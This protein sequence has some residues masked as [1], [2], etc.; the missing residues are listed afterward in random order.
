M[1][2][3]PISMTEARFLSGLTWPD[4]VVQMSVNR[5]RITG[6]FEEIT[7]APHDRGDFA[8]AIARHGGQ[9][10][11]TAVAEDWCGDATLVLPLIAR[12]EA[13]IPGLN[14]RLFV[15]SD[16][17]DLEEAYAAFG[18]TRIPV[19]SFFDAD[20]QE[21]ARWVERS[22]AAQQRVD[23]WMAARPGAQALQRSDD[24]RDRKAYRALMKERLVDMMEWYRAGLW[25]ATL[26]EWKSLL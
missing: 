22:A 24:P 14:L 7:L 8:Q 26:E 17:P 13:E 6:L 16:N 19:I 11:I 15:R 3:T 5:E 9:L 12:L 1:I 25:G 18:V 23:V 21:V 20:W 2:Q 10:H 4:Y